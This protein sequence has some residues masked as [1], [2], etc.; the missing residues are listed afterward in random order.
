MRAYASSQ[1]ENPLKARGIY[2]D[3]LV[4]GHLRCGA[5]CQSLYLIACRGAFAD[6]IFRAYRRNVQ[7]RAS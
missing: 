5:S 4:V 6:R 2:G 7:P 1:E 3:I